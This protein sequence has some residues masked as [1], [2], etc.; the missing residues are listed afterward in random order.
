MKRWILV[1]VF[2]VGMT[3]C[4]SKAE[5]TTTPTPT[6][7]PEPADVAARAGQAMAQVKALHF[8]FRRDGAPAFVDADETLIF[9]SAEGD[10]IAPDRLQA[11]VK[12][13]MGTFVTQIDTVVVEKKQ[14][15]TNL[16]TGEWEELPEGWGLDPS[17]FF[18]AQ[19]GIPTILTSGLT[20]VALQGPLKVED[21]EGEYLYL[22]GEAIGDQVSAMSGGLIPPGQADFEAWID[23][24]TYL[25]Y[26]VRLVLPETDPE[27]PTVWLIEF[28]DYGQKVAIESPEDS[29]E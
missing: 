19:E 28:S 11:A 16:L 23:P 22:T 1:M 20:A 12:V 24:A 2:M 5:P 26:R 14:W 27:D 8:T 18:D 15:I 4:Q 25:V 21:M 6:P 13:L 17:T 3:A 10:Y 29:N 9:R 7:T